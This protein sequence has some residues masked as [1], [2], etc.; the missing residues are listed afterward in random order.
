LISSNSK[1]FL[2]YIFNWT[3]IAN[4]NRALILCFV[5][6]L[7]SMAGIPPLSGF[8]SKLNIL[9]C[10]LSQEFFLISFFI[11]LFS[12][13]SCFFYIRL[14]KILSFTTISSTSNWVM[15]TKTNTSV[16]LSFFSLFSV[17][18][19][20]RMEILTSLSLFLSVLFVS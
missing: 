2:K 1:N 15:L 18:I 13:V 17:L 8:Y 11:V 4:K 10:L 16:I 19:L 12:C 6:A 9:F 3:S 7:F 20:S 5:I 14:I